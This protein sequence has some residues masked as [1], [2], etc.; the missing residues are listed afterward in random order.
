[1]AVLFLPQ[2]LPQ[3][4]AAPT[5]LV[6][7]MQQW[8]VPALFIWHSTILSLQMLLWGHGSWLS[9]LQLNSLVTQSNDCTSLFSLAVESLWNS[10][11]RLENFECAIDTFSHLMPKSFLA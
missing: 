5:Q 8:L 2:D 4:Q 6:D 7:P 10:S 3:G 9:G 11:L 1:M